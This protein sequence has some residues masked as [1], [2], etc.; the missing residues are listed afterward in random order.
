MARNSQIAP[1]VARLGRTKAY[2]KKGGYKFQ[3]RKGAAKKEEETPAHK[4]VP[5]KG[6]KNG[7]K[8]LVPT[9]KAPRFYPSVDAAKP[10]ASRKVNKPTKL[11][12]N[13]TPGSVLI[14]LAGR[15]RGKRVVFLKQL[16]SGLL[17]VTGPFKVNG[18]PIRRVNQA[19]VI[20]TSTKI[21]ISDV[22]VDD[23]IN[24]AYFKKDKA[25]KTKPEAAF[26]A[27]PANK[28]AHPESKVADQK[29]LD[30][31]VIAAV[32]KAGPTMAKYLAATFSL[33]KGEKPH[34]LKF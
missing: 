33:S 19:Y 26:F 30:K 3:Q 20:A 32:K 29:S 11:K 25:A 1:N 28:Q 14:L 16:D 15:F 8:R 21:D 5:V 24:D 12:S 31:A 10:K 34:A 7:G 6:A 27:D 13:I 18:V 22:K 9:Q 17:L 23:K 4:E 2:Q